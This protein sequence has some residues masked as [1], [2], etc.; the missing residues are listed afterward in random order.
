MN[1]ITRDKGTFFYFL[2][3]LINILK[4]NWTSKLFDKAMTRPNDG[5]LN[6]VV[7]GYFFY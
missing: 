3:H 7:E 5:S 2:E 6:E 1:K 4:L